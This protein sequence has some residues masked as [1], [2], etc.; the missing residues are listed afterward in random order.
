MILQNIDESLGTIDEMV[1][2]MKLAPIT[3]N[4]GN[5]L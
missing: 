3:I 4:V 5:D 1:G 2:R